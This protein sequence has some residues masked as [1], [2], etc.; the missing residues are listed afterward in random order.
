MKF[1]RRR[2]LAAF[3]G[4][5][6]AGA[7]GSAAAREPAP[8]LA[9]AAEMDAISLGVRPNADADQ[10]A[11]LQRAVE[12]AAGAG[13]VLRL[14]PGLY[15]AGALK[16]PPYAII[17]GVPGSTRL[18][19]TAGPSLLSSNGS[20]YVQLSNLVLDGNHVALAD[21][22]GLLQLT[23][24]RNIR[25]AD[26]MI[27]NAGGNGIM[28]QTV[29]G[30][31]TGNTVIGASNYAIV[32]NDAAG[33]RIAGNTVRGSG[34]SGILVWRSTPGDDGTLVVD[35]R[36]DDTKNRSGGS[37]Q[38]GNAINVFRADNVIVRGNRINNAAY[39]AV[40]GNTASN[41][42]VVGNTCS[43]LGEVAIYAEF[44][45]HGAV[46]ANNIV[47]GAAVGVSIANFMDHGGRLAVVQSNLIR[48]LRR[49]RPDG[50]DIEATGI[51]VEADTAVTGNVI[52]MVKGPGITAGWGPS[53]RDVTITG[54]LV[55]GA[56]FGI[57]VSV[58]PEAGTVVIADNLI[59]DTPFGA[60]VGR[61]WDKT[62]TGDLSKAGAER[63]A[64]LSISGNRVR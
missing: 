48:N 35:N 34:N 22:S 64:Q 24:G 53:L 19:M 32:S 14:P 61:E 39:S 47:D 56:D 13:A 43:G 8:P 49:G 28:L 55:R 16:L 38:W 12:Q 52:E 58:V 1:N 9:H 59:A 33:L 25:I 31:V 30:D 5:A 41:I 18:V 44:G 46:I 36:I 20:D 40:R 3:A 23:Q 10:S 51:S 21:G 6:S 54:N 45:F 17:A 62:V 11:A 15:R 27:V 26:C 7:A 57:A 50:R 4:A 37:G 60:I 2:L 63:Y 42:Q 29:A